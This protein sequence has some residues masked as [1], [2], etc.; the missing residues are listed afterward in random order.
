VELLVDSG[1]YAFGLA[2]PLDVDS[3]K[4]QGIVRDRAVEK[5]ASD[6]VLTRTKSGRGGQKLLRG[7]ESGP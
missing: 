6:G 2:R 5:L 1:D 7:G 4:L 3:E